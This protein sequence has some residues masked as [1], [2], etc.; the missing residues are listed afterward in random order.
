MSEETAWTLAS[1]LAAAE[2]IAR[3][4]GFGI[5]GHMAGGSGPTRVHIELLRGDCATSWLDLLATWLDDAETK[6]YGVTL[7]VERQV[8]DVIKEL[9]GPGATA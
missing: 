4:H 6:W 8:A 1:V 3:A 2:P 9:H 5:R 7:F